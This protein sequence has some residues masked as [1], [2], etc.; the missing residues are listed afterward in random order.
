MPA[1]LHVRRPSLMRRH[2]PLHPILSFVS[3]AD[4]ARVVISLR[5]CQA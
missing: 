2:D 3:N 4:A 1:D 5:L